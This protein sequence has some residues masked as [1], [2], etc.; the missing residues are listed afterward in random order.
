M[1]EIKPAVPED[2]EGLFPLFAGFRNP[3]PPQRL[4]TLFQPRW[5][6]PYGQYGWALWEDSRAVGFLGT[7]LSRRPTPRGQGVFCNLSLWHVLPEYRAESL[8]LLLQ[9]LRLK[10]VVITNFTGN[11]VAPIL[12]KFGFQQV[13]ECFYLLLPFPVPSAGQI[14]LLTDPRAMRAELE[15]DALQVLEDH[16]TL[17][18]HHLLV[19]TRQGACHVLYNMVRKKGLPVMQVLYRSNTDLFLRHLRGVCWRVCTT[20]KLAGVMIGDNFLGGR[21]LKAALQVTQREAHLFR[22][23]ELNRFEIDLA[24]S[25]LQLFGL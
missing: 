4:R 14:E 12:R 8:A 1:A 10:D 2:F 15:G 11:K 13:D 18:C 20:Q 21:P 9:A 24:Y 22:S 7:L 19:K 3:P 23:S 17:P 5:N 16:L 6:S 25:E